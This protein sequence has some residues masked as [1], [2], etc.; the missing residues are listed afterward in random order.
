[1]EHKRDENGLI[2]ST[3]NPNKREQPIKWAGVYPLS[4][5][6]RSQ[7]HFPKALLHSTDELTINL[8]TYDNPEDG[9]K[10]YTEFTD[11]LG[12]TMIDSILSGGEFREIVSHYL[13][14]L[15]Q[16]SKQASNLILKYEK[17]TAD[18][19]DLTDDEALREAMKK[20]SIGVPVKDVKMIRNKMA[21][22]NTKNN[23]DRRAAAH[24]ILTDYNDAKKPKENADITRLKELSGIS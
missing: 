21:Q 12:D 15:P 6:Y 19:N 8:G 7:W 4:G 24:E 16:F 9:A 22:A 3:R 23:I 1:M 17:S 14:K 20:L 2:L 18:R 5:K 10:I 13:G 11:E